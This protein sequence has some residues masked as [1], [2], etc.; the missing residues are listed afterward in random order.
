MEE[1][2]IIGAGPCGISTAIEC[3][4]QGFQPLIIEKGCLV[5]SIY[6]YPLSMHFFSTPDNL[7]IGGVPFISIHDKPS[8]HEALNYYRTV[9]RLHRLRIR[10]YEQVTRLE[11]ITDGFRLSTKNRMGEQEIIARHVVIA[12]G[13]YDQPH[14]MNVPGEDLPHVYHYFHDAHPYADQRVVVIGGRNSAI[15]VALDL[16][17]VGADVTMVYRQQAFHPSVKA[18]VKPVIESAIEKERIHMYWSA[19]VLEIQEEHVVI[20]Q[21]NEIIEVPADVVFAM[22]GYRPSLELVKQVGAQ[23]DEKLGVPLLTESME[24][25]ISG[26]YLAGVV[27]SGHDSTKIFIENGRYHGEKIVADVKRKQQIN[28]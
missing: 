19:H 3:K 27:A 10:T 7:E 1:V 24:T 17:Q 23:I 18:W 25:T 12:T 21:G 16:Q 20:K 13:Y 15:D 22:T 9:A 5:N 14:W 2:V 4:K 11:K 6:H 26:L 28:H 8:R